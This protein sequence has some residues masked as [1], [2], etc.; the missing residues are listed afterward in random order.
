MTAFE[1]SALFLF[2]GILMNVRRKMNKKPI[3]PCIYYIPIP[4]YFVQVDKTQ[5]N[6][7][8]IIFKNYNLQCSH[9]SRVF[10]MHW[11]ALF[12]FYSHNECI[13]AIENYVR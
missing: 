3:N 10:C 5:P 6:A 4:K 11:N 1:N 7:M 9:M 13:H 2:F 12:P 8:F